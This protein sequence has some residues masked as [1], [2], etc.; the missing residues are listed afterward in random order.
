MSLELCTDL[1]IIDLASGKQS[2]KRV[3]PR[4]QE[5]GK[6]DEEFS[7]DI[8]EDQEKI[9]SDKAEKGI[10]LG[11]RGLLLQVVESGILG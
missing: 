10:D 11:D 1:S 8:E 3:I 9:N 7:S 5:P 4:D 2:I 6:V